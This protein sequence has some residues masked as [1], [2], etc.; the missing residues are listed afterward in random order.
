[1]LS[2]ILIGFATGL[3]GSVHCIGMCGPLALALPLNNKSESGK[4]LSALLYNSGRAFTYFLFGLFFGFIGNSLMLVGYQQIISVALGVFILVVL[5][6]GNKI[7]G[8]LV[9]WGVVIVL[10]VFIFAIDTKN[11]GKKNTETLDSENIM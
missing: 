4:V 10:G 6:F 9:L 5:L 7:T 11:F 2:H 1:M 3:A 8:S